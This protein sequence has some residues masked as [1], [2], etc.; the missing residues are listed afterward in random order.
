MTRSKLQNKN[1]KSESKKSILGID[2]Q[3][4]IHIS[5]F[6]KNIY[7]F[8]F[9]DEEEKNDLDNSRLKPPNPFSQSMNGGDKVIILKYLV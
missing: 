3:G 4:L 7:I 6:K 1:L 9:I 2:D 8:F 5:R